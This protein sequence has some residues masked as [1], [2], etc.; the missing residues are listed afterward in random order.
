MTL[1]LLVG[2]RKRRMPITIIYSVMIIYEKRFA[3]VVL[4][5]IERK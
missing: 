5:L 3:I 4:I 1:A 2:G